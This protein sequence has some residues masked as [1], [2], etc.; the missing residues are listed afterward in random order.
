[1][2]RTTLDLSPEDTTRLQ[3]A[4]RRC[5]EAQA[6]VEQF[7]ID[8]L[9]LIAQCRPSGG[10]VGRAL[11]LHPARACAVVAQAYELVGVQVPVRER[12]EL[13]E[14][15]RTELQRIHLSYRTAQQKATAERQAGLLSL[16]R[17]VRPSGG[18]LTRALNLDGPAGPGKSRGRARSLILEATTGE[19]QPRESI[20]ADRDGQERRARVAQT[21][22]GV[23]TAPEPG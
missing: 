7:R 3:A 18:A 13:S 9:T 12:S 10:S 19:R 4:H 20:Q 17:E 11:G 5:K 6:I 16:S 2:A 21:A 8:R 23:A 22:A 1:M 14:E 15:D